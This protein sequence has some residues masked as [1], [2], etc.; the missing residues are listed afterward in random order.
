MLKLLRAY[1][2]L[3]AMAF[4]STVLSPAWAQDFPNK[5]IHLVVP[6]GPGG[7]TDIVG[8]VLAE[9]M[10][11]ILK[12]PVIVENRSG[13]GGLVGTTHVMRSEPDGHTL[14]MATI[15]FGANPAL[16]GDRLPFDPVKDFTPVSML[17]NVPTVLVVHPSVPARSAKELVELAMKEPGTLNFG[18]AGY[19]TVNHL[20]G[21]MMKFMADIDMVH[22]PYRSGGAS[23]T[24]VVAGEISM[25]F[26]TTPTALPFIAS[27]RLIPLAASG[28]K[29]LAQLPDVPLLQETIPGFNVVEWQGVVGPAGIPRPVVDKLNAAIV[30]ALHDPAVTKRLIELGTEVVASSPEELA[31]HVK[32]EV[33]RWNEVSARTGMTAK[34]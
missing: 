2:A 9:K 28:V 17:V 23:S 18:S 5:P 14:L 29:P 32:S 22:I 20:A 7:A 31:A 10:S 33:D 8:R 25:L 24:A 30:E 6:F 1:V 4:F 12:Q 26:A 16:F 3:I 13:A 15:G 34:D 21:E 27:D 11:D 19:G